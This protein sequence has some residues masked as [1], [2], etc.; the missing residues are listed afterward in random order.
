MRRFILD[1]NICLTYIRGEPLY[2]QIENEHSL[3]NPDAIIL[4][5]V[6]TKA[7]LLSLGM[8]RGWE[9][10]KLEKLNKIL[11]NLVVI[12][13][14]EKDQALINAYSIIDAFSQGKLKEKPLGL[15]ARNM[16]KNDLWIAST[17]HVANATLITTDK[18][19]DHLNKTF[20][21]VIQY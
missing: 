17:A 4:I 16:G 8:Q 12:D 6:V 10:K 15:S 19:F 14:N 5:S 2:R 9:H 13:I 1:T 21:S 3:T 18:D 7:E 11:N 20:I